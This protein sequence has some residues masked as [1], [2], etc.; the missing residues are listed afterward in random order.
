MTPEVIVQ[1]L[2]ACER[3]QADTA[4][5]RFVRRMTFHVPFEAGFIGEHV[6]ANVAC[7]HVVAVMGF[8]VGRQFLG[9][10]ESLAAHLTHEWFTFA[11][12]TSMND[13]LVLVGKHFATYIASMGRGHQRQ[14]RHVGDAIVRVYLLDVVCG[15]FKFG[16]DHVAG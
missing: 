15:V 2:L 8:S 11:M 14:A 12:I 1:M 9:R 6:I 13:Q 5:K 16:C 4:R 7:E 10:W 3:F